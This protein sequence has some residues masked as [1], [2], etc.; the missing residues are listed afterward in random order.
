[1][2]FGPDKKMVLSAALHKG[3]N[4]R[5]DKLNSDTNQQEAHHPAQGIHAFLADQFGCN[6]C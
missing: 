1:L 5:S 6:P 2:E 4:S 3:T